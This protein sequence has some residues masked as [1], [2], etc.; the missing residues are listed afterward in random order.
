MGECSGLVWCSDQ[1][2]DVVNVLESRGIFVVV[3]KGFNRSLGL[4]PGEG[5]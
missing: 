2:G 5:A 3:V 4:G 1:I